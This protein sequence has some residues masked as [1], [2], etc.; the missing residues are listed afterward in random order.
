MSHRISLKAYSLPMSQPQPTD[1]ALIRLC[2]RGDHAAFEQLA[3]RY[4]GQVYNLAYR[5]TGSA[6][7]AQDILQDTLTSA[8]RRI[9]RFRAGNFRAWILR[10]AANASKDFLRSADHRRHVSLEHLTETTPIQ[11]PDHEESPEDYSL[12]LEL[13]NVLQQAILHLPLE[14]RLV[15]V[16][17]D[18]QGLD[19][20]AAA[21]SLKAPVGTVKSRLS[22]ARAAMKVHLASHTELL[23]EQ[24]RLNK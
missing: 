13:A 5:M 24:F 9:G 7:V 3:H 10:I 8:F 6:S 14:Q 22:R 20:Q 15:L 16:L 23:P 11:W 1:D 17:I 4:E 18:V 2:Q 12:R 21:E 19:Y